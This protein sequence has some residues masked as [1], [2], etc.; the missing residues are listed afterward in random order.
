MVGFAASQGPQRFVCQR[1]HYFLPA[2]FAVSA[3]CR[4]PGK[5]PF[6]SMSPLI[7]ERG[8]ELLLAVGAS[9]GPRIISAVL[10][11]AVRYCTVR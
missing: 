2:C 6:S 4:R 1:R 3:A 9:G 8:G 7:A 10:Q 11:A 5:K